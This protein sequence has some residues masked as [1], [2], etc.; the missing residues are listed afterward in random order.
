MK[1]QIM[2][3]RLVSTLKLAHY[4]KQRAFNEDIV[5]QCLTV[6]LK[7][8]E[9]KVSNWSLKQRSFVILALKSVTRTFLCEYTMS[10]SLRSH[11]TRCQHDTYQ[12]FDHVY[13]RILHPLCT[14]IHSCTVFIKPSINRQ[15]D[16]TQCF[17]INSSWMAP[18]QP[19][20]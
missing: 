7:K 18:I 2:T 12:G 17:Q 3:I 20:F 16:P 10:Q 14:L 9:K 15:I 13:K 19:L 4:Y 8:M 5:V 6:A 11:L 1:Q